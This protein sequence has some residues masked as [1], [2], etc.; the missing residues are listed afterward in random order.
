MFSRF[1]FPQKL[2]IK[3][4][5]GSLT[6]DMIRLIALPIAI[7]YGGGLWIHLLHE[8]EGGH[9][10]F[11]I[12]PAL[13]W[14]RDSTLALPLIFL[15]VWLALRI[16]A[17]TIHQIGWKDSRPR[18]TLI[19]NSLVVLLTS[20]VLVAGIPIHAFLFGATTGH[21][22]SLT[23]HLLRDGMQILIANVVI[24]WLFALLSTII[25]NRAGRRYPIAKHALSSTLLTL[26]IV[27]AFLLSPIS[28]VFGISGLPAP[29]SLAANAAPACRTVRADV[30][31]LDQSFYYNR[32]GAIQPNGMIYALAR[33]VVVN[34]TGQPVS[35]LNNAQ[36]SNFA[37]QVSLRSDKRPRP[38]VLRMNEGDCLEINFTNLLDPVSFVFNLPPQ[39]PTGQILGLGD[40]AGVNPQIINQPLTRD[41]SIHIDSLYLKGDIGS[42]GSN[43]GKNTISG[44]V[45]PGASTVYTYYAEHE[46]T[47]LMYS[48]GATLGADG[49][50]GARTYGLFG[51]VNV[52]PAGAE[53]YRSQLT[54]QEM[55]WATPAEAF[56]D[57]NGNDQWDALVDEPWI[58]ELAGTFVDW[59]NNSVR[60]TGIPE[61][62][63]DTNGD[64]VFNAYR[65][66]PIGQPILDYDAVYPVEA[67]AAKT[68]LPIINMLKGNEIVH[69]DINAIITGPGRGRFNSYSSNAASG[70][71]NGPY[72]EFTVIFHDDA[73]GVQ[74]FPA[75]FNDPVLSHTMAG[76]ADA[77]PINYGS[78]GI[79]SEIVA[80]RLGVGPMWDCAECKYEEFFLTS[81]TV[82]D[83]AMIVDIPANADLNG[84]GQPD[85]GAKATKALYP[86]DPSNVHHSYLNDR[87][88]FR[89]LHAGPKEH[90]IF[91]LHAHQWLF[92][93]DDPQSN[94]LDGQAIGPGSGYT[95][96]IAYGGSGN[97]NKTVGDSIFHCHFYPHFAQ[98]MWE[99]WRV[100]DT[101][102]NGTLMDL[103]PV[104]GLPIPVAGS[105]ALPDGEIVAGTPIPALVPIPTSP[106]ALIPDLSATVVGFDLNGDGLNDS[107]QFDANG[108]GIADITQVTDL[109]AAPALNPGY[110]WFTP[111][112]AGHRPP[113]PAMDILDDGGLPRHVVTSGPDEDNP[114]HA[115]TPVEMYVSR[116]D[117]NKVLHEASAIQVPEDGTAVE[118]LAMAF[119]AGPGGGDP[120]YDSYFPNGLPADGTSGFEVNGLPAVPGAP[121]AEPCRT[122]P[123]GGI[124]SP[125]AKN[126]TI[127]GANIEMPVILNK[128][129]WHFQQQRFEA[130]W[131]DVVPTLTNA[132]APEP[133]IMRLNST[134]CAEF[135]HTN[136]VPNVYQLDD[137]QVR[138]PT[139][140]IGQHI[141]LVKFD[142]MS[143]DGSA[144]G[145]NYE[146]GTLSPD[147]VRERIDAF[148]NGG[149]F[150]RL[151]GTVTNALAPVAHPF[152]GATGP[153]GQNWLGARTTIQRW[154]ADPLLE[155]SWDGGVG[156]VFTHD[157]YGPSTHQQVGL[158]STLL[159]EPE[160]SVWKHNETGNL[161]GTRHDG[162]PTTW[163]AVIEP[164]AGGA[165]FEAHREFYFE[166][167]DF[168]H[169]YEANGGAL[170]TQPNENLI[171]P[172]VT[173]P[174]Y[175]DFAAA[176]NPSF[177]L[178][179]ANPADIFVHPNWCPGPLGGLVVPRPC[180]EAISADDPGTY[181]LNFRNE[182]IGLRVFN[183][184]VGP[185]AGQTPGMAG[186]LSFAY[187]SRTDRAIPE[188]NT[189]PAG[190]YPPLTADV[191]P[192]DPWTPLLRVYMGDRVRI[193]VQV[194][195]HEEEHNFTIPGLKWLKEPNSPN[196]GWKNSEFFGIDEYFNLDVPIVP[197]TAN[198][199]PNR[200]DYIYTVGAELEGMWNG[201]WGIL[202]TYG[203]RRNDLYQLPNNVVGR[204]GY[205]IA[206]EADFNGICPVSA[207]VKTFDV[208]AVRAV[209]ILDPVQGLVYNSRL[210]ILQAP[211]GGIN[212]Q[213]PLID[214]T[215]LMYVINQDLTYD[216]ATGLPNGLQPSAPVE[217]LILRVNAGDCVRVNLTNALPADLSGTEMPGLDALPPII[218]KDENVAI[219]GVGGILTFNKNDI[220][221]SSYVGLT[222]QLL[223]FDPRSD[224]GFSTGL[225]TGRLVAPGETTPYTW[226]AGHVSA[227]NS[228]IAGNRTQFTL[229]ATPVEFGAAGLMPADR[230]KGTENGLMGAIIVEPLNSCWIADP[231]TRAQATVWKGALDADGLGLIGEC[232]TMPDESTDSFRDFVT[233][234]QNDVN[235]RY[236][237]TVQ[238]LDATGAV[239]QTI[240]CGA[241]PSPVQ[242]AVP[243]IA[244]EGPLGPTEESQDSGQK[245]I[246]YGAD[247]LWF[248]L[249]I[250]PDWAFEAISRNAGLKDRIRDVFSN[251][252]P[253]V[254]GDPQTV[255]YRASPNGPQYG[256][257]HVVMPGGHARGITY[258][259]H[260]HQW[261]FQPYINGS[262]EI[263]NNLNSQYF[264]TQEGINPTGHWDFV[265]NL[266][267]PFDVIGDYLWR[268]QAS[269]GS[270]QGLWG[271]LRFDF[272][273]SIAV[274]S[275]VSAVKYQSADINVQNLIFDLDGPAGVTIN[276]ADGPI[277]GTL[278]DNGNGTLT[279]TSTAWP[280]CGD[281]SVCTDSFTFSVTDIQGLVSNTA[282][283]TINVT[284]TAPVANNDTI[285]IHAP[286]TSG[287][288]DVLLND[289]DAEGD[290][291]L[292]R[293]PVVTLVGQPLDRLGNPVGTI[294]D[295]V[296][297]L[298]GRTVTYTPPADFAGVVII[299]YTVMD[300]SE[301]VSNQAVIRVAVN[302]D[303]IVITDA[304]FQLANGRWSVS[305][306]CNTPFLPDGT[307]PTTITVFS[308]PT[309]EGTPPVVGVTECVAGDPIGTWS[310][311]GRS[312]A[313][314]PDPTALNY[315]SAESALQGFYE[316]FPLSFAGQNNAPV[317][318]NDAFTIN[319]NTTLNENVLTNDA[320]ADFDPL[321]A[322]LVTGPANGTLVLNTD[323]TFVYTPNADFNGADSFTYQAD[324]GQDLSN[325]ATVT[326]TIN[327]V[328]APPTAVDD[329]YSMSAETSL[330]EGAPG[331]LGN[332]FDVEG[333]VFTLDTV[334]VSG[335][336]DGNSLVLNADG[337]FTYTPFAGD[338][339]T[340]VP[341]FTG[342][343][344]FQYR[345]CE[346]LGGQN[347]LCS[348]ATVTISVGVNDAP[349]ATDDAYDALQNAALTINAPGVLAN[350]TDADNDPLVVSV[351]DGA[352]ANVGVEITLA[353][354]ATLS[355]SVDGSLTYTPLFN[356][357]GI[358][359]FTYQASD[360]AT[361]SNT[362]TVIINV[363]DTVTVTSA[364]YRQRQNRWTIQGTV[365]DATNSV[366]VYLNSIDPANLIGAANVNAID[367]TWNFQGSSLVTPVAGNTVIAVSSGGGVS[368]PPFQVNI[369]R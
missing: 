279:Y 113:T 362:A 330:S 285:I 340:L 33:D 245:A 335:P 217:P 270:F 215:V 9:E 84:D 27:S 184:I 284:N 102:E 283:V 87:V 331:V 7:A 198:G 249:G 80:N 207:P 115:G 208:T 191:Q 263:G 139:D 337:S 19:T 265:V 236:G 89:N 201:V 114:A 188:L 341:A 326:I 49:G 195:A 294:A 21:D 40:P 209:D 157:H 112:L 232:A 110:P 154:Y 46:A 11:P 297:G 77:F 146:D 287:S 41:A 118:K 349:M 312:T 255:V 237:G 142:V 101:F 243:N 308:G 322:I 350:D 134:D 276:I 107:S 158:Y 161:L 58:D 364:T 319:E 24:V 95:Y 339:A 318:E 355:L 271:L 256:R 109:N 223:S 147:E 67:G 130:L 93:P 310:F 111:G 29:F 6:K 267:G 224:G 213:G 368:E 166:F 12:H 175:A 363:N 86:D 299:N 169:A 325:I 25:E 329:G 324:D 136:L 133:M 365:S 289:L 231:G 240:D 153:G 292:A 306:T 168:Q 248:R 78:G 162:G 247:P 304:R 14:L 218:Q 357:T 262:S 336:A 257:F 97:R 156:T 126:R 79:G 358:D 205:A 167:A 141:H 39:F 333:D 10:L 242:C 163:Q 15:A 28:S 317:A 96:E 344:S 367:G 361:D 32:L 148:N 278:T 127:K 282:T 291:D 346:D 221:P 152:F 254:N 323:G 1:A 298:D 179:P 180:P 145:F 82:G 266:G 272:T 351:V 106:M 116:L 70:D 22:I 16:S 342:V 2:S 137:F 315:V 98:G 108:D 81:F 334:P 352:P 18:S 307:T 228:G 281:P 230:V 286:E 121:F 181:A 122:D 45:P 222:P 210:T 275:V 190:P 36:R 131:E 313:P 56:T 99:L 26:V 200:V 264:G 171:G 55:D 300:E 353:S 43:V 4:F 345:I 23:E 332:D 290:L 5:I 53:W 311:S 8:I 199:S 42:D 74:A 31:A 216:L 186:D 117:F 135:W 226:Y 321:T 183:G 160:G 193:R 288:V 75:F 189:Q 38:L 302:V 301:A 105:R 252:L 90:H 60:D 354:G 124:V 13:H 356:F 164:T 104:D 366:N 369:R 63:L 103:D 66:T 347:G 258:T 51:A 35:E 132:R 174:S 259:L 204:N 37:G 155:R 320:D 225:T 177:R 119:H 52:Q 178:P 71:R 314:E 150:T 244:A 83:P 91:H 54:R 214:P 138:T 202:R 253:G 170:I 241:D 343:D 348:T 123:A 3:I 59:N 293:N 194:G 239:I 176:I 34:A 338:P 165:N 196:S 303:D 72:R 128:V 212:G 62:L 100:H 64:N 305:G 250:T 185:G 65:T 203:S 125:I 296:V 159:V 268:D 238:V 120:T 327:A 359:S 61:P 273:E 234:V 17:K 251:F 92:N 197:D 219:P 295:A 206:N 261:Q 211:P 149:G 280:A 151:D 235:L 144:N 233:I 309:I 47:H 48:M 69:S 182:P 192:G 220:T 50:G 277:Y 274:N 140:I 260:G 73:F 172:S 129:G 229:S 76:V 143:A 30:V 246:N 269:F 316:G 88:K 44:L 57:W 227:V 94:Y 20:C 328:N 173:I 360:G 187:Q 68:G 85:P